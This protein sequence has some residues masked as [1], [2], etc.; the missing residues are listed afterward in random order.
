MYPSKS[1]DKLPLPSTKNDPEPSAV[2]TPTASRLTPSDIRAN[3]ETLDAEV[4]KLTANSILPEAKVIYDTAAQKLRKYTRTPSDLLSSARQS[5]SAPGTPSRENLTAFLASL[6]SSPVVSS[7]SARDVTPPKTA[8]L[9]TRAGSFS[10][11][12]TPE[13]SVEEK[14]AGVQMVLERAMDQNLVKD[15]AKDVKEIQQE[16][17]QLR[18]DN[19]Q[20]KEKVQQLEATVHQSQLQWTQ[21]LIDNNKRMASLEEWKSKMTPEPS[22]TSSPSIDSRHSVSVKM[23]SQTGPGPR[24]ILYSTLPSLAYSKGTLP[25]SILILPPPL[26]TRVSVSDSR[27]SYGMSSRSSKNRPSRGSRRSGLGDGKEEYSALGE[28]GTEIMGLYTPFDVWYLSMQVLFWRLVVCKILKN[29]TLE[30]LEGQCLAHMVTQRPGSGA[31]GGPAYTAK[32]FETY[33]TELWVKH[34]M[35]KVVK[36][37]SSCLIM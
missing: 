27:K 32:Q 5:Q 4:K 23:E 35:E 21:F 18:Q 14:R 19:A 16:N 25:E 12:R 17:V 30:L 10:A 20:L 34:E 15:L 28:G 9:L 1:Q 8:P 3:L 29:S 2:K 33:L 22:L 37:S 36:T 26:P 24:S 6:S 11:L 13:R 31:D 7:P